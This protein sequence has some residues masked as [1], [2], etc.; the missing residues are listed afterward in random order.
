MKSNKA[1]SRKPVLITF[2]FLLFLG[3]CKDDQ[4]PFDASGTFEAE[5]IIVSA[6]V[7]GRI[8]AFDREEGDP[9]RSGEAIVNIDPSSLM[10][11]KDVLEASLEAIPRK[12]NSAKPQVSVIEQQI[13]RQN[14][15]VS[16]LE[17]QMDQLER[18][19]A[20]IKRMLLAEAA[21]QKQLDDILSQI[22][23]L[24]ERIEGSKQQVQV[25]NAQIGMQQDVVA[26]QNRGLFSG[27]EPIRRQ[28]AQ[29]E[30]QL[31]RAEVKSPINGMILTKYMHAGEFAMP[32]KALFKIADMSQ[33]VLRA[34]ISGS[35]LP[36]VE[37]GQKVRVFIDAGPDAYREMEGTVTW[38]ADEAE[39][40]PKT[41]Q[42]KDE[43]ADLVYAVKVN[44]P[45]DGAIKIG[46]YGEL[47]LKEDS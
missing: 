13:I 5:E 36:L 33:M 20:R 41:I 46:M 22:D 43:R 39:F 30:D 1:V 29:L 24:R 18:E 15:E 37:P 19:Q 14:N 3:G 4:V 6:E 34:Y 23:V 9:V 11:Q 45:N 25:L 44:V 27:Q 7:S 16:A 35:Q 2:V 12:A 8:L 47:K 17:A 42:T 26:I 10:L 38:I 32:G 31:K 40:T 21:T 28:I